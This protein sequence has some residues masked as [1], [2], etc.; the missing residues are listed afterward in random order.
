MVM[1][2]DPNALPV[3]NLPCSTTGYILNRGVDFEPTFNH[4]RS[5]CRAIRF[6]RDVRGVLEIRFSKGAEEGFHSEAVDS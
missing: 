5:L 2:F 1:F 4:I 3:I 6:D